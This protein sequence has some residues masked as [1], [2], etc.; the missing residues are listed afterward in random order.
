MVAE[1]DEAVGCAA[2]RED[3]GEAA[4]GMRGGVEGAN[5]ERDAAEAIR[6]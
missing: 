2:A 6:A 4:T 1:D 5:I 3:G